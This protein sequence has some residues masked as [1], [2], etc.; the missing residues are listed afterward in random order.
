MVPGSAEDDREAR[1]TIIIKSRVAETW[2][3]DLLSNRTYIDMLRRNTIPESSFDTKDD[4]S[5]HRKGVDS[6]EHIA[7]RGGV[8]S[9]NRNRIYELLPLPQPPYNNKIVRASGL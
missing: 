8:S 2:R 5:C 3:M 1:G 6:Q 9:Q 7:G 4:A